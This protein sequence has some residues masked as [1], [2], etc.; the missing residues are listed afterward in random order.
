[1]P[2]SFR[3]SAVSETDAPR[4]ARAL[5][6]ESGWHT[7]LVLPQFFRGGFPPFLLEDFEYS[8]D[9]LT[10]IVLQLIN[11]FTLGIAAREGRDLSPEAAVRI[12][13]DDYGVML[14]VSIL[15]VQPKR[16]Q[17]SIFL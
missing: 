9:S 4:P 10:D 2:L 16:F 11:R 7:L 13:M 14:H 5:V 3:R 12:F 15:S 17:E 6:L 8:A 1:M